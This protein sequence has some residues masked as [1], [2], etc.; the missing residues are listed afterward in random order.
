MATYTIQ[1]DRTGNTYEII[2]G[3]LE[4]PIQ[5]VWMVSFLHIDVDEDIQEGDAVTIT[6]MDK[7]LKGLFTD[8]ENYT[9]FISGTVIG[10][11]ATLG[12]ILESITFQGVI[13]RDIVQYIAKNTGHEVSTLSDQNLL[14]TSI[15]RFE[16]LRDAASNSLNKLMSLIGGIWRI[17]LDGQILISKESYP[18][19]TV[20]YPQLQEGGNYDVLNKMPNQGLWDIYC[21]DY[22][23][24][25]GF[26]VQNNQ[27]RETTYSLNIDKKGD[28]LINWQFFPPEHITQYQVSSQTRDLLFLRRYRM[29]VISQ[30]SNGLVTVIPDPDLDI[31]KNGLRD[32]PIVYTSPNM[33]VKVSPGA[34]CYV[35]FAN[36]DPGRPV[37]T[38][39]ENTS[40]LID[41][42]IKD[43][44]GG[45]D[46][47]N[48]V[49]TIDDTTISNHFG[50]KGLP[51]TAAQGSAVGMGSASVISG[52][53]TAFILLAVVN[54]GTPGPLATVTFQKPFTVPPNGISVFPIS[55]TG[56]I[57]MANGSF[58]AVATPSNIV[59][60]TATALTNGP[61][62]LSVTVIQ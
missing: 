43:M 12:N 32:I 23:I 33:Q 20:K 17:T 7:T 54:T 36:G 2:Q 3:L 29:K 50:G 47:T 14:N 8:F 34:I 58:Y 30:T 62:L 37:V 21:E 48:G 19:I 45:I 51:P 27:V 24:E 10:G 15:P 6:F 42:S 44:K 5:G 1:N 13:V 25:P 59:I 55:P 38:G 18:D 26:S 49:L 39:W 41:I 60:N 61:Y 46:L 35:E 52:T 56:A 40:N 4:I 53:D 9:G 11:K 22:L 16:K 57:P 28:I 31:L